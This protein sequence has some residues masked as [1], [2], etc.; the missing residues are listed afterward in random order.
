MGKWCTTLGVVRCPVCGKTGELKKYRTRLS[1]TEQK[2][3]RVDHFRG[4]QIPDYG[5]FRG[6]WVKS[7]YIGR[8]LPQIVYM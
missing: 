4:E 7:C 6:N 2:Y 8:E 1:Q 5:D 3:H